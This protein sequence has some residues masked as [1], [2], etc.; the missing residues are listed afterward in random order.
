[1]RRAG[2]ALAVF[3]SRTYHAYTLLRVL[4]LCFPLRFPLGSYQ[5]WI[6][7]NSRRRTT[8]PL[9]TPFRLHH[10]KPTLAPLRSTIP[11]TRT[12]MWGFSTKTRHMSTPTCHRRSG[13]A[14]QSQL[15]HLRCIQIA[16]LQHTPR[17]AGSLR[18]N[19]TSLA[20][21]NHQ[22]L[23]GT[24]RGRNQPPSSNLTQSN[25]ASRANA[26]EGAPSQSIGPLSFSNMA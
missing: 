13:V 21:P 2:R 16:S 10:F 7:T 20:S 4:H 22:N 9:R 17:Q 5:K 18:S 24:G 12:Q 19:L 15:D 25:F 8:D 14:P 26:T 11:H 3:A 1:M 6:P 23:A